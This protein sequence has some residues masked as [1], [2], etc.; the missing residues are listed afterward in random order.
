MHVPSTTLQRKPHRFQFSHLHKRLLIVVRPF[1]YGSA[2]LRT[3]VMPKCVHSNCNSPAS[4]H[5]FCWTHSL[6][7]PPKVFT[8]KSSSVFGYASNCRTLPH[9][10]DAI[11][12]PPTNQ[13]LY[14]Y[15]AIVTVITIVHYELAH[16]LALLMSVKQYSAK[17]QKMAFLHVC[18][19]ERTRRRTRDNTLKHT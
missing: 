12:S 1:T 18:V 4:H 3:H 8:L 2:K 16:Y 14:S 10:V 17:R 13:Y 19:C 5:V 11:F 15:R 9:K 7:A 6:A